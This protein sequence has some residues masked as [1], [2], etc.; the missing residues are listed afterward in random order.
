MR[1]ALILAVCVISLGG[2]AALAV[3]PNDHCDTVP[4]DRTFAD[5]RPHLWQ[6]STSYGSSGCPNGYVVDVTYS[7]LAPLPGTYMSWGD[8]EPTTQAA[9]E[10]SWLRMHVWYMSG[11]LP[12]YMGELT[13]QGTWIDNTDT[14]RNPG[15]EKIC[16]VPPLR[17][18]SAFSFGNG[19]R[20]RFAL[21]AERN[22]ITHVQNRK[23]VLANA[24]VP[25]RKGESAASSGG[26]LFVALPMS[27]GGVDATGWPLSPFLFKVERP[28]R[29]VS[30]GGDLVHTGSAFLPTSQGFILPLSP[31][32][33]YSNA[34]L[35]YRGNVGGLD[36][37]SCPAYAV[38]GEQGGIPTYTYTPGPT[39]AYLETGALYCLLNERNTKIYKLK[40]FKGSSPSLTNLV[41]IGYRFAA[42]TGRTTWGCLDGLCDDEAR[43]AGQNLQP[44]KTEREEFVGTTL[45]F[46]RSARSCLEASL[47]RPLP[48]PLSRTLHGEQAT[49]SVNGSWSYGTGGPALT[50]AGFQGWILPGQTR[51]IDPLDLRWE[52]HEPMHV[53]SHYA[54]ADSLPSWLD[55]GFSIQAEVRLD[56]GGDPML[57]TSDWRFWAPGYTDGH[58]VG[59]ELFRRLEVDHGC[60]SDCA[61]EIWR[62]LVDAHGTDTDLTNA[63]IKAVFEGRIGADL[64]SLFTLLGIAY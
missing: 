47:L 15:A 17:A 61:A 60:G 64:S 62:D 30:L 43:L 34:M 4:A 55:E 2:P 50:V 57:M 38:S 11:T 21:R 54:F 16:H 36:D 42:E 41:L 20:Y 14:L 13:S 33:G 37:F 52:L 22:Y 19:R 12:A 18:E 45:R 31:N 24:P 28:E 29:R 5:G 32:Y 40:V 23:L 44:T 26:A 63:E 1:K 27:E 53:F 25:S 46:V 10:Q 49:P 9:C 48:V 3:G 7:A 59:S 39:P 6:T 35:L 58:S 56:C 51:V 8:D